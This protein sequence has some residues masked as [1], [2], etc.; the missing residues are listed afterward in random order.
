MET[1]A[2]QVM[3][4]RPGKGITAAQSDEH[5][6]NWTEKGWEHAVRNGNYDRSREHLNF[7]ITKGG[8]IRPVD[9]S[10]TITGRMADNLRE[11]GIEDPNAGRAEPKYRTV[12]NI[13]FGGSRNRMQELAF[14][15]Q[16]VDLAH[17]ADNSR[18]RRKKDIEEWAKDIYNFACAQWGEEN[19]IG[20]IVHLDEKNPHVHCT[21]LPVKN[22]KFKYK[23]IFGGAN[24]YEY[25]AHIT[26]LH[27][28]L[29]KV[30]E[31]WGLYRGSSIALTGARHRS[32]EEYRRE[33]SEE[34]TTLEEQ[35]KRNKKLLGELLADI[36]FA[37]KRVK[38]LNTMTAN[39]EEKK[40]VLIAEMEA[41]AGDLKAGRGD[42]EELRKKISRLDL[43]LQKVLDSLAD[44]QGKLEEANN[45]LSELRRLEEE[46]RQRAEDYRRDLK[47]ATYNLEHQVRYRLADALLGDILKE[48]KSLFP[49]LDDNGRGLF[50]DSLLKDV[51]ERGEDIFKCA[52]YL[53]ANYVD[54]ATTFAESHGGGGGDN[55]LPWGRKEDEDDRAWARRCLLRACR[56]MKPSG[57]KNVRRKG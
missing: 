14:G 4:M 23:E 21:V 20:F 53:F 18:I 31:K 40:R 57:G 46:T 35:I 43:D 28:A 5:Q 54:L 27:D 49:A 42:S 13:I 37:E 41:L 15:E 19:V 48:F 3:D 26:A 47:A 17:G 22:G 52:V 11:R 51:A 39:L 38:G 32:T 33:L 25:K 36:R 8:V 34:C 16:K 24:K 45:K 1:R 7:E 29:S 9:K 55:D 2:K 44:K 6:R 12:V 30:N 10:R 50:E 56:M